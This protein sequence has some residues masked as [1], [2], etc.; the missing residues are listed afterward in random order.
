MMGQVSLD[1]AEF[2]RLNDIQVDAS[3]RYLESS[4]RERLEVQNQETS[5]MRWS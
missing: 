3:R 2:M 1:F 4:S 5:A